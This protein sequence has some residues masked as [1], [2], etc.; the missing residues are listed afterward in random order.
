MRSR[1]KINTVNGSYTT[2][3]TD[4]VYI[5]AT[6]KANILILVSSFHTLPFCH[7][8]LPHIE[9]HLATLEQAIQ[10]KEKIRKTIMQC[11]FIGIPRSGK[12][13]L[14]KRIVGEDLPRISPSTGIAEKAVQVVVKPS[15]ACVSESDST[16]TKLNNDEEAAMVIM[17]ASRCRLDP[18]GGDS[19][20]ST[21]TSHSHL[22]PVGGDSMP[23][24]D[25][26]HSHLDPVGGDSMP[27]TDTSHSHLDPVGGDSMPATDTS[28]SHLD[29]VGGDS[30]PAT[31]TSHSH[32]DPVGGD[33][34]PATDTSHSHLDPVGGDSMPATD[35]SHSHLD[36]VGGDSMPATDT[37]QSPVGGDSTPATDTSQSLLNTVGGDSRTPEVIAPVPQSEVPIDICRRALQNAEKL[38]QE[39]GWLVYLTDTGGQI[40]FQELLPQFLSGPTVFFLVFR[41]DKKLNKPFKV[42]YVCHNGKKSKPY[43]STLTVQD[44]L[45]QSLTSIASMA[46]NETQV[47]FVGTHSDKVRKL[48]INHINDNLQQ[49]VKS[50]GLDCKHIVR[51]GSESCMLLTVN[52]LSDHDPGIQQVRRAMERLHKQKEFG[53]EASPSYLIFGLVIRQQ[54]DSVLR[55]KDCLELATQCNIKK[56]DLDDALKVLHTKLG[57][58]RHYQEKSLQD[59]VILNPQVLF[60]CIT[61]LVEKATFEND[62]T[63]WGEFGKVGI[64]PFS[65]IE[66]SSEPL[67]TSF[68]LVNLLKYLHII[69]PLEEEEG[70]KKYFM[71]CVLARAQPAKAGTSRFGRKQLAKQVPSLLICFENGCCPLGLFTALVVYLHAKQKMEEG[72]QWRLNKDKIFKNQISF[73]VGPGYTVSITGWPDFFKITCTPPSSVVTGTNLP[74]ICKEV[75]KRLKTG[76]QDVI[77]RLPYKDTH[78]LAFECTRDHRSHNQMDIHSAAILDHL[79]KNL[80]LETSNEPC[81]LMCKLEE[82]DLSLPIGHEIWFPKVHTYSDH[83]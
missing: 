22:D 12:T 20:P 79:G 7:S 16:W 35:T 2:F 10:H 18:V 48:Q 25:T 11:V 77:S 34:M 26:S 63:G 72:F 68:W 83:Y 56:E 69:A 76:I 8:V 19:M 54:K 45:I 21:D 73:S 47:F 5:L 49:L 74:D 15:A 52:N 38:I 1:L 37:S 33:S 24:T 66:G 58:I 55:Y 13:S 65:T 3:T 42:K 23:A 30:M 61:T 81:I 31:D 67:I 50:K 32:L 17:D 51:R 60:D 44:A 57:V 78:Y 71:P 14:M 64:F 40:E 70:E 4:L 46:S 53:V 43:K 80:T 39:P 28:H 6:D 41:L 62:P 82:N 9:T 59:I 75:R 27:A 36:P 29:P